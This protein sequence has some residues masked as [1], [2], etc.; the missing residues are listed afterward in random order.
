MPFYTPLNENRQVA[1]TG[2]ITTRAARRETS[3]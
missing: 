1:I 3:L 2:G